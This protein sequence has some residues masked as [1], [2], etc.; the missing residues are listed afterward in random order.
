MKK[1]NIILLLFIAFLLTGCTFNYDAKIML[2]GSVEESV[3][4]KTYVKEIFDAEKINKE[5]LKKVTDRYLDNLGVKANKVTYKDD[6]VTVSL[7]NK[8]ESIDDFAEKSGAIN[9]IF[10]KLIVKKN[11]KIIKVSSIESDY[12]FGIDS[13]Y[14]SSITIS[15]PY[16]VISHNANVVDEASNTYTWNVDSNFEGIKLEYN[17]SN[18]Y[19]LNVFKLLDY[20]TINTFIT[21]IV[22]IIL[23]AFVIFVIIYYYRAIKSVRF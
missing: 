19:T 11:K 10:S 17:T 22:I 18:L 20:A 13:Y 8:Y 15:L 5:A 4:N 14:G 1:R 3:N 12:D 21:I 16:Q 9:Q 23:V 7:S 2:D 6:S